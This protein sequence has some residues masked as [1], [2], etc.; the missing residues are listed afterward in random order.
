MGWGVRGGGVRGKG[1]KADER[2][3]VVR[4][5]E[6]EESVGIRGRLRRGEVT[7]LVEVKYS[8]DWIV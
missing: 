7:C 6:K 4:R 5:R 3:K 1:T 2:D 8:V